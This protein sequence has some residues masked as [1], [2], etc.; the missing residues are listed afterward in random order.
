MLE[1]QQECFP[2]FRNQIERTAK[3]QQR[4][5]EEITPI[6]QGVDR[7]LEDMPLSYSPP[8]VAGILF[9]YLAEKTGTPD[10][11]A[12]IKAQSTK[13]VLGLYDELKTTIQQAEAPLKQAL[14]FAAMGNAIDYG[15][16]PNFKLE[17]AEEMLSDIPIHTFEY[18]AFVEKL[19]SV[20]EILY[21]ADNVGETVFDRLLIETLDKKVTYVVKSQPIINDATYQDAVDAGI[22]TIA[23]VIESGTG[24]PGTVL[25]TCSP[26]FQEIFENAD[27]ILSKGQ[28]NY[29][30]LCNIDAPIFFLLKIKC[31]LVADHVKAPEGSLVLKRN[32]PI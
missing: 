14:I 20:D 3:L 18:Q 30:A 4:S 16:N 10:P 5:P 32:Q 23:N 1:T 12:E 24:C 7:L 11:Y 26:E 9:N 17:N 31:A 6:L 28:G 22:D 8:Q 13:W 19:N 15:A 2:C 25:E 29:E 21:L 27:L